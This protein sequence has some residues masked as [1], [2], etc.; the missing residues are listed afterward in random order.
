M[1]ELSKEEHVSYGSS[2][3][4]ICFYVVRRYAKQE[5]ICS[6]LN[7]FIGQ[8]LYFEK[9]WS[10]RK[11]KVSIPVIDMLNYPSNWWRGDDWEDIS[12]NDWEL[13]FEQPD[14]R[15][16][17]ENIMDAQDVTLGSECLQEVY[18]IWRV[19]NWG[20][21]KLVQDYHQIYKKYIHVNE[22]L[23]NNIEVWEKE[24]FKPGR[25]VIG[26]FSKMQRSAGMEACQNI[27]R[28]K[29]AVIREILSGGYPDG[30]PEEPSREVL[31][32]L[33]RA[34]MARWNATH[35]FISIDDRETTEYLIH[36]LGD[37][38]LYIPRHRFELFKDGRSSFEQYVDF[39]RHDDR[40]ILDES[41]IGYLTEIHI[42]SKCISLACGVASGSMAAIIMNGCK[43][44]HQYTYI[45]GAETIHKNFSWKFLKRFKKV[46]IYGTGNWGKY[47]CKE[48]FYEQNIPLSGFVVSDGRKKSPEIKGYPIYELSEL[49]L[50]DDTG[51][52]IAL[53]ES[54]EVEN[55]LKQKNFSNYILLN[56]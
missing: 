29:D 45:A 9:V 6:V 42:L 7:N 19:P 33:I 38:V 8:L 47:V 35:V 15:F 13:Y 55:L 49:T 24:I 39:F 54:D 51:L 5:G 11:D 53:K 1:Y 3:P 46:F 10:L 27:N 12:T 44:E 28:E 48:Y 41:N 21:E 32:K 40:K 37:C 52:I 23:K 56:K 16:N 2:Y 22:R 50:D 20:E 31:V 17:V 36:E 18:D 26:F 43:Y 25:R 34:F 14:S 30:Y 4:D